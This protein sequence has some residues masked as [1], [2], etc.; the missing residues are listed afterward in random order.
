MNDLKF[1]RIYELIVIVLAMW[2]ALYY[3]NWKLSLIIFIT[4][5]ASNVSNAKIN[6]AE[7]LKK[8]TYLNRVK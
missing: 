7:R 4:I 8:P 2:L 6:E 5:W 1:W 3:F